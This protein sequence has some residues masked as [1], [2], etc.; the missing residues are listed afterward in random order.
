MLIIE[1]LLTNAYKFTNDDGRIEVSVEERQGTILI[2]V[3]DNGIGIP[4]K[5]QLLIFDK[6]TKARRRGTQGEQTVGLGM[7]LIR[8]MVEQLEGRIWFESQEGVGSTFFVELPK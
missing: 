4:E 7:H 8:T 6:F 3:A 1:N 2:K 5:L